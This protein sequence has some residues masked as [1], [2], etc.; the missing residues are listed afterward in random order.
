MPNLYVKWSGFTSLVSLNFKSQSI[1]VT[2]GILFHHSRLLVQAKI[3][4]TI[5]VLSL[6]AKGRSGY[7]TLLLLS[8]CQLVPCRRDDTGTSSQIRRVAL[9]SAAFRTYPYSVCALCKGK[10]RLNTLIDMLYY[11]NY[12]TTADVYESEAKARK[13][14]MN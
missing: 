3:I 2:T 11:L 8:S 9:S 6:N 4:T 13:P 12:I 10:S 5:T 7:M 14:N 1:I